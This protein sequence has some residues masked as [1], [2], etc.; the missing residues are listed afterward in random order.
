MLLVQ[1]I[2]NSLILAGVPS[3]WQRTAVGLL[4][5]PAWLAS[6]GIIFWSSAEAGF[7]RWVL[8]C[9]RPTGQEHALLAP[10]W[11][12][13]TA[14][15][16][17]DGA[18]YSLWIEPSPQVNA[19][20]STGRVVTVTDWALHTQPSQSL[21]AILAHELG[22]HVQGHAWSRLLV[23]WYSIPCRVAVRVVRMAAR[24]ALHTIRA[25]STAGWLMTVFF[26]LLFGMGLLATAPYVLL[27]IVVPYAAA[28][29]ARV[30]EVRADRYAARIGYGEP[31]LQILRMRQHEEALAP[32]PSGLTRVLATHPPTTERIR[33]LEAV[34]GTGRG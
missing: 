8:R 2:N 20:A 1:V 9:R 4:L 29:A 25:F 17:V 6:G 14:R 5:V 7:A 22:H 11:A 28:Y 18:R 27:L 15:A 31:L 23:L 19:S 32:Q 16:G 12:E 3:A 34:L 30:G 13:V 10:L 26:L 21:A 24:I 33:S